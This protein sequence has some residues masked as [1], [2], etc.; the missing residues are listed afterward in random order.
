MG[1][2]WDGFGYEPEYWEEYDDFG[3]RVVIL[4]NGDSGAISDPGEG[5]GQRAEEG[6]AGAE[7]WERDDFGG[8][9]LFTF[10]TESTNPEQILSGEL[11]DAL[12]GDSDSS[13]DAGAEE[14]KESV[15]GSLYIEQSNNAATTNESVDSPIPV[16]QS[17]VSLENSSLVNWD[18]EISDVPTVY[19]TD[20]TRLEE[21]LE[22]T[23]GLLEKIEVRAQHITLI[24]NAQMGLMGMFLG[25]FIVFLF[26]G[27]LR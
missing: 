6:A 9:E 7:L 5:A 27:R 14:E 4:P 16:T 3:R 12:I 22:Q 10:E 19:Q 2:F 23:N 24:D 11:D 18:E 26:I 13:R 21:L 17:S 15:P 1:E 8:F 25:A 20:T